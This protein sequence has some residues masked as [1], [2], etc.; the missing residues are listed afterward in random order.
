MNLF[1][2]IGLGSVQFGMPYGISNTS[3]Q[4]SPRDVS[5]ILELARNYGIHL[6]DTAFAYGNA[7]RV[8]GENDLKSFDIVSKF[9]PLSKGESPLSQ[10]E[11]SLNSLRVDALYGYLAHRPKDILEFPSCWNDLQK[12]KSS[13]L[14]NKIG[15]SLNEPEELLFL[16]DFRPDIIQ[17]PFNFLDRR[18]EGIMKE[19]KQTGCE[20]HSR[21]SFLQ[22]LFFSNADSLPSFFDDVKPA[23]RELQKSTKDLAGAL[24]RFVLSQPY[25][26]KVIVGVNNVEQLKSNL[27]STHSITTLPKVIDTVSENIL[28]P[29]RWPKI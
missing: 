20:I 29:S 14:V 4:T 22:G 8:L 5:I 26:D 6:I 27:E 17:V 15:F 2:K 1:S 13:G 28:M 12:A 24:L 23:I 7:E 19:L 25:I 11:V 18:F 3:G 9:K 21:S 10:L 16:R